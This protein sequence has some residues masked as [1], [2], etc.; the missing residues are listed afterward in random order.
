MAA[1]GAYVSDRDH[2][3]GWESVAPRKRTPA[4]IRYIEARDNAVE[5]WREHNKNVDFW[6]E[7]GD[8]A[9][10]LD[11]GLKCQE[12]DALAH[13]LYIQWHCPHI[14]QEY[15]GAGM[16]LVDG[17]PEDSTYLYCVDCGKVMDDPV[18]MSVPAEEIPF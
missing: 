10:I 5:M 7:R 13:K 1:I 16:R 11:S 4:E 2:T 14:H 15:G 12:A 18:D 17:S 3:Y 9:A 6:I 8:Y